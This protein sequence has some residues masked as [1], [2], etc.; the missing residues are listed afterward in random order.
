MMGNF[1]KLDLVIVDN[2]QILEEKLSY[3]GPFAFAIIDVDSKSIE[4]KL[5]VDKISNIIGERPFIFVGSQANLS[6]RVDE[7]VY[8]KNPASNLLATP[9]AP[10]RFREVIEK[11]H[12]W[13]KELD[14]EESLV[15]VNRD[16]HINIK[17][18]SFYLY[19]V[20]PHDVYMEVTSNKFIKVLKRNKPY[21]QAEVGKHIKRGVKFF[22]LKKEDQLKLL[23]DT[24]ATLLATKLAISH[25]RFNLLSR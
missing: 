19:D 7:I 17:A 21:T 22:Y 18:K 4:P 23:E 20:F 11:A 2:E 15:D 1:T 13:A 3:D 16:D 6:V 9:I 25:G 10:M 24:S 5:L 14:F 8:Q 12:L